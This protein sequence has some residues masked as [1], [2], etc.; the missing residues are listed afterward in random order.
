MSS[1]MLPAFLGTWLPRLEEEMRAA[2]ACDEPALAAF[3]GMQQYHMGWL[4]ARL[5]P[6]QLPAGKRLRPMLCL[7][8]CSAVG[9]NP[10]DALAAA[11]ALELVH[12][13][14]LIHDDVEDGDETRRHRPTVWTIWGVPHAI[15][16]GDSMFAI[17]Y[18]TLQ[19]LSRRGVDE[20]RV[21]A[22]LQQFTA[23]CIELTEGQYLDMSFETRTDVTVGEYMRMIQGKTA[24]LIGASLAIGAQIGGANQEQAAAL[25]R[26][27]RA[28]GL[29]FQIRD[30]ILGIWGDPAATGKAAGNDILRRK[31]SLPLLYALNHELVGEQLRGYFA[32]EPS[33][34]DMPAIMTLLEQSGARTYAERELQL[35]HDGGLEALHR[36]LGSAAEESMLFALADGMLRRE[37]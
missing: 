31:K 3:Y 36:A 11:A 17:S 24:S 32:E 22:A 21:L 23:T 30:D 37:A 18:R 6:E 13:F 8:S 29:T 34:R 15:N 5:A 33:T 28:I 19:L 14:S 35:Q 25:Q 16:A 2:L 27:G 9:G 20:G 12:N 1:E 4:N 10:A 26:F 7:L